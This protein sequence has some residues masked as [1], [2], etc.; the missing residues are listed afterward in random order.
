MKET[1][2][3]TLSAGLAYLGQHPWLKA[4]AI[5]AL[6][7]LAAWIFDLVLT[8]IVRRFTR[9]TRTDYDDRLL[10]LIHRPV[11]VSV[12]LLAVWLA[13]AELG[14][15]ERWPLA[16]RGLMLTVLIFVWWVFVHRASRLSLEILGH[17]KD[18]T[19]LIQPRTVTLLDNMIKL[20]VAAGAI[21]M[22]L[23]AWNVDIGPWLLSAGVVGIA[24]GLAAKDSLANLFSG[25]FILADAPY[26]KGDFIV[27][28]SG[29]RGEV[30]DIGLRSTRLLTR[31]DIEVTVPNAVIA[32]AKIINESGGPWRKERLRV[33]V[34][35]A[36]GS[37]VDKVREVLMDV[38][39]KHPKVNEDPEPRVRFR[40]FGNSSL[41]FELLGWIDEPV[42]RGRVLDAL[43]VEVYKR[44]AANEIEIPFPKRD[45]YLHR[46]D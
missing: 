39:L 25:I 21:Y 11:T 20:F 32:N 9:R 10:A 35:V 16:T 37:D 36:Y 2:R 23:R 13:A 33:K 29:E 38:A 45:V 27:L 8:R 4:L 42:L 46:V 26:E 3:E 30:T 17:L 24:L 14:F 19:P 6:G 43:N 18:K 34:G 15:T 28:D 22:L 44:F 7:L 31:D 40:A 41:D 12:T 5:V 1:L